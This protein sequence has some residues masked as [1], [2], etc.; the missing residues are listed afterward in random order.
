[1]SHQQLR[2]LRKAAITVTATCLVLAGCADASPGPS[3][4]SES[5]APSPSSAPS[6]S[7]AAPSPTASATPS[8]TPSSTP[9]KPQNADWRDFDPKNFGE[10]F[11]ANNRWMPLTPGLQSLR[12]GSVIRGSRKLK[13]QRRMTV[14]DVVKEINGVRAVGVLD[15][16][17]DA[18]QNG[19][20]ALDWFAQ[21]KFGNVWY[22]GSYTEIYEGGEFVN[23]N[24]G[25]LAGVRE[26]APGVLMLAAPK[27]GI[28]FVEAHIP[29]KETIRAEIA[30]VD[31]KKCVPYKCFPKAV[32]VL[33]DG[34]EF[35]WYAPGV[36]HIATE[37]NYTG[38]E[39][40]KEALVNVVRL[41]PKGLAEA[42]REALKLD[43]HARTEAKRVYG[44]SKPAE[45]G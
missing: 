41:T 26:A 8:A 30:K 4:P 16:D 44:K 2:P 6:E 10:P 5:P 15:Q 22:M 37:P 18:G 39:Q 14:T 32:A 7:S 33:E 38:G 43:K 34:D 24:D 20:T 17:I 25:W 3:L 31:E 11:G 13:H 27:A 9:V 28:K 45:R 35:K 19:E 1:M 23:A 29:G 21:D 40:E 42:S 36:G 12:D